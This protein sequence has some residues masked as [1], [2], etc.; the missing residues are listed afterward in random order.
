MKIVYPTDLS[1]T[2]AAPVAVIHRSPHADD[3]DIP[4]Y[5]Y[6]LLVVPAGVPFLVVELGAFFPLDG[7]VNEAGEPNMDQT[8]RDAWEADFTNPDGYGGRA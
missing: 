1:D 6:A 5:D 7:T 3:A 8:Y 4:D 2:S